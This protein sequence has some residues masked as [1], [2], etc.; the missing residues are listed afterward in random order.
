[1]KTLNSTTWCSLYSGALKYNITVRPSVTK[2]IGWLAYFLTNAALIVL[3]VNAYY[4]V[5]AVTLFFIVGLVGL[6][7][8]FGYFQLFSQQ[9]IQHYQL[10]EQ[11][12]LAWVNSK[13]NKENWQL[14]AKSRVAFYG[15]YVVLQ[16]SAYVHEP[17]T[18]L[19]KKQKKNRSL[20]I[21]KDSINA[22]DYARLCRII[23]RIATEVNAP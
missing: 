19:I 12:C 6:T 18:H 23:R 16:P 9:K 10:H 8:W 11:G 20:F 17:N 21:F 15:C 1:M 3:L 7:S 2:A 5:S 13:G 14:M 22:A 4:S